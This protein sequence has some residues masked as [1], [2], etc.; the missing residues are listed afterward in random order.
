MAPFGMAGYAILLAWNVP[1]GVQYFAVS[2]PASPTSV[3]LSRPRLCAHPLTFG[4]QTYLISTSCFICTGGNIAWLSGNCAPDG[5]R[6]VSLGIQLTLTNIGG[7]VSGQIYQ[8]KGAPEFKLG[9]GW[10]FGCL[11]FAFTAW[12][13]IRLIYVRREKKKDELLAGGWTPEEDE[14]RERDGG[15]GFTDRSPSFRYQL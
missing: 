1:V 3:Q 6:A 14:R 9:H 7:I 4:L 10:S 12:W 13:F 8:T 5:K 11:A 2:C 15:I